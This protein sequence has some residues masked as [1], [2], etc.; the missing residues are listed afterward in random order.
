MYGSISL[1]GGNEN[2]ELLVVAMGKCVRELSVVRMRNV[3]ACA[4]IGGGWNGKCMEE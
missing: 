1:G 2:L 4:R 3:S